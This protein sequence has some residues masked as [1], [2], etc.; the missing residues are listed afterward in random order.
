MIDFDK[1]KSVV[2]SL[3]S[4]LNHLERT[5]A[6][7]QANLLEAEK[8][9][10]RTQVAQE[11]LQHLAQA[12]QQQAHQQISAVVSKCL[13]AVF[14]DDAYEFRIDFERKRGRTEAVLLFTRRGLVVDPLTASGG[15]AVDVAAFALR[16]ACLMLHRP[17]LTRL[18]VLDEPMKFVSAE[19][20]EGVRVMLEELAEDLGIQILMV[21]HNESLATGKLLQL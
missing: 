15:G 3:Q 8:A 17:R 18:L 16:V 12:V 7:E 4:N 2:A 14:G 1:E 6:T 21:T 13:A 9:L 10:H 20:Q 11:I 19:Y 5:V